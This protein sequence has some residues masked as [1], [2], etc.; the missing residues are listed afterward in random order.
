MPN[1]VG[2][3]AFNCQNAEQAKAAL[4]LKNKVVAGIK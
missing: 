4:Q 1:G 3:F 2:S